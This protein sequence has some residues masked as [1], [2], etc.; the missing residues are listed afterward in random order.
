MI[1]LSKFQGRVIADHAVGLHIVVFAVCADDRWAILWDGEPVKVWEPHE[2]EACI[3][4][5]VALGGFAGSSGGQPSD[6]ETPHQAAPCCE[7]P[8][9][10]GRVGGYTLN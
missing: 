9:C 8:D 6:Y 5:F 1:G 10:S 2:T 7:A 3:T 4:A